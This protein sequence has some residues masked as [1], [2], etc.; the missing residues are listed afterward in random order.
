MATSG[1][2]GSSSRNA[3][4]R[5]ANMNCRCNCVTEIKV[6]KS[7]EN[8]GRLYYSCKQDKCKWVGWCEPLPDDG[9]GQ[10]RVE[11]NVRDEVNKLMD[12]VDGMSEGIQQEFATIKW[13]FDNVISAL[14]KDVEGKF[15]FKDDFAEQVVTLKT[16]LR[17]MNHKNGK[18][19]LG[20]FGLMFV[21]VLILIS[22][23]K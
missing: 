6:S 8:P 19:K 1:N 11:T 18:L 13:E 22:K 7:K 20:M 4:I 2:S 14:K 12:Q 9:D 17:E 3:W 16:E 23:H 5:Y 10:N 21:M 15:V